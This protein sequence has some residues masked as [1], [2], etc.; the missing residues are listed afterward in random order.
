MVSIA[1]PETDLRRIQAWCIAM[2]TMQYADEVRAEH[3]IRG[4]KVTLC[5]TRAPWDGA[6]DW[7]H[8]H[9]AQ[10]RYRAQRGDWTLHWADRHGRWHEHREGT[11]FEGTVAELLD[12]IDRDPTSIFK[13]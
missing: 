8:Y 13:G 4:A 2:W 7:T 1:L 6:G 5:E 10:L 3:H 12:E 9:F 11:R